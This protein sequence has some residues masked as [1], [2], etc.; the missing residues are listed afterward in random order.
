MSEV[1][2]QIVVALSESGGF[3]W[4]VSFLDGICAEEST[5]VRCC[6][7]FDCHHDSKVSIGKFVFVVSCAILA[8]LAGGSSM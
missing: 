3:P 4:F 8:S 1:S 6:V 2:V 7:A 5:C